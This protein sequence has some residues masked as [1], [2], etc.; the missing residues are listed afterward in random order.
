[1]PFAQF[2]RDTLILIKSDG[3]KT[4][5][6]KGSVQKNKIYIQRDDIHIEPG[7]ELHRLMPG[8]KYEEYIVIE[9][10]YHQRLHGI[11]AG[12]QAEV[13]RK[14]QIGLSIKSPNGSSAPTVT[15]NNYFYGDNSRVNNNSTDNSFNSTADKDD[16][17]RALDTLASARNEVSELS[18]ITPS[19]KKTADA[20]LATVETQL[21][22][23]EPSKPILKA[24]MGALPEVVK[25][26]PSVVKLLEFFKD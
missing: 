1:M 7:D 2:M 3:T 10:G 9:P 4:G 17:R 19:D 23:E 12:Y 14:T 25:A 13:S 24:V 16:I 20:A 8:D 26:L 15:N 6:I 18:E 11:P 22:V 21:K 5:G